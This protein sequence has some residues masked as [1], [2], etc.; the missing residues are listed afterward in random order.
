MPIQIAVCDSDREIAGDLKTLIDSEN[1]A[2][3][4]KIFSSAEELLAEDSFFHIYF[5]DIKGIDGLKLA[6]EIR[7]REEKQGQGKSSIIFVTGFSEYMAEAFDVQAFHYLLKPVNQEKFRQVLHRSLKEREALGQ[8]E[9]F[10]L[11]N[12]IGVKSTSPGIRKVRLADILYVE[13]DNKK[14]KVHLTQSVLTARGTMEEF[15]KVCGQNFYRCHRCYL[16]NFVRISAYSPK[17][18]TVDNGDKIMLAYKKYTAFVKAYLS[19]AKG[20]GV[21]HV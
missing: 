15:A 13:S 7:S 14:V 11:L 1:M 4:V 2:V 20:G 12:L 17:E 9:Q 18:I 6:R 19:Y 3:A 10:I 21:V 5:L 8:N 16:V